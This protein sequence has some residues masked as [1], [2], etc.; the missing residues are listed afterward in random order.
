M[1]ALLEKEGRDPLV[2]L[3]SRLDLTK[4]W[5]DEDYW[6]GIDAW[7]RPKNRVYASIIGAQGDVPF[8]IKSSWSGVDEFLGVKDEQIEYR[9]AGSSG[10]RIIVIN[11]RTSDRD[12][13]V[14]CATSILHYAGLELDPSNPEVID[15]L[16]LCFHEKVVEA[17]LRRMGGVPRTGRVYERVTW[18][19][20]LD[21][22]VV[23]VPQRP[24]NMF[25]GSKKKRW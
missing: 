20:V 22:R 15:V 5:S 9:G 23:Q 2:P 16:K 25:N 17:A 3:F 24:R 14:Q 10:K 18:D 21:N 7:G 12:I 1:R 6:D 11:G 8:Q 4:K 19:P 13:Q